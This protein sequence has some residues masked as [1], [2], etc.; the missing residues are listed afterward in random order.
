MKFLAVS[1]ALVGLVPTAALA[2]DIT[3]VATG[4]GGTNSANSI[5]NSGNNR[6]QVASSTSVVT[7]PSGPVPDTFGSSITF[8]ARYASLAAADREG[9]ASGFT[10]TTMTSDYTI[11]FTV[12][13][14]TNQ[15]YRV[16]IDTLRI[17][18]FTTVLDDAGNTTSSLG[19][20]TGTVDTV[21]NAT[22]ALAAL[23]PV[24]G[25]ATGDTA[26]NQSSTTLSIFDSALTR[27][28]VLG[29]TWTASVTSDNLEAAIRLGDTTG[30]LNSTTADDYPGVGG[31]SRTASL[32]GHFVDVTVTMLPEPHS[33]A[34]LAL[35]LLGLGM[36]TR[37]IRRSRA[38][39]A[40]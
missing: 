29:F 19:A 39:R 28:F 13:N 30:V 11:T 32:D 38:A 5:T 34:L 40:A 15:P 22:L 33:G 9:P 20:V 27:T 7:S 10:T 26:I 31:L 14:P 17:G 6:M 25:T 35:G 36:R 8:L 23:G 1:L 2:L 18:A 37:R 12:V 21:A 4:F 24:V 16:D 3:S